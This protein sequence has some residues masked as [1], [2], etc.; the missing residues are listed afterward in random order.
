MT[1]RV[2]FAPSPTGYLHVGGA[3]TALYNYLFAKANKGTYILR[4]EDTDEARSTKEFEAIQIA[5]LKWLGIEHTEGPDVGGDFGPYRQSERLPIYKEYAQ[6]LID[7]GCAFYCF[8]TD[9]ELEAK[10]EKAIQENTSQ[11]Y[12][13]KCRTVTL[14]E[15]NQRIA[16]GEKAVVR[17]KAP[18]KDYHL[19]DHVRGDV[20]FPTGM[21]GDFVIM[22][23]GGMPVF[24]F[25]NSIDDMLMKISH[26]IRAEEHLNNTVRQLMIYEAFGVQP[27]EYAHISLLIGKDRQKL[28]KR[29]G[30]TSVNQYKEESYLPQAMVNYLCQLG[31]SHPDE[32]DIFTMDEVAK[33]FSID[34]FNKSSAIF[35]VEK[36]NWMNG[37]HLKLIPLDTLVAEAS[38]VVPSNHPF[39]QQSPQWKSD[40]LNFYKDHI[41][42]YKELVAQMAV[43]FQDDVEMTPDLKEIFSWETTPKIYDY[44]NLE[45]EKV[46]TEFVSASQFD[47][48]SNH[49]KNE[50]K[51]K[52]K[53][54]FMGMRG[55]LTGEAHGKELKFIIPL[56]PVKTLKIR[57]KNIKA[58]V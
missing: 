12:D 47:E 32:K 27:P 10:R 55:V 33:L 39:H 28:S 30:A 40:C 5:D 42:F 46:S 51:I 49:I 37:Q 8:C 19:K 23:S 54:L 36:L 53:P 4:V 45:L 9:E 56:T 22:R 57:M 44:L 50:L 2:R 16:K 31:W 58:K 26:V 14:D 21:I 15:A 29:H 38:K 1:V 52:G 24:N 20:L 18:Q 35:D 11:H 48:W 17:F 13:G 7:K 41:L 6:K 43:L 34:R 3:R 25:V